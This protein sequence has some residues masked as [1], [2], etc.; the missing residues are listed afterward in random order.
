MLVVD[1][2]NSR[3][4]LKIGTLLMEVAA[5]QLTLDRIKQRIAEFSTQTRAE[6]FRSLSAGEE[7]L[8]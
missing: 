5:V 3:N 4:R 8:R 2:M 1:F 6:L 7:Y